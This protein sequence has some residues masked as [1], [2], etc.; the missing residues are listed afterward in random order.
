MIELV[1][2]V[3]WLVVEEN[4]LAYMSRLCCRN[5]H[6]N[7]AVPKALFALVIVFYSILG[8]VNQQVC[9]L[10]KSEKVLR[11]AIFPFD[12]SCINHALASV[13]DAINDSTIEGMARSESGFYTY[14][15]R[16]RLLFTFLMLPFDNRIG[17]IVVPRNAE[18][19]AYG[20]VRTS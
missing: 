13:I 14:L 2:I 18:R 10:Y 16:A 9:A 19:V 7:M 3:R 4:Q 17:M 6:I 5:G 20:M 8:I 1:I 12:I 15:C 11:T